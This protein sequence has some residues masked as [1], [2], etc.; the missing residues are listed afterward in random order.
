MS[1][2]I[3]LSDEQSLD[4]FPSNNP[5]DFT[6]QLTQT[7]HLGSCARVGL[8]DIS[9]PIPSEGRPDYVAVTSDLCDISYD[10]MQKVALLRKISLDENILRGKKSTQ[11]TIYFPKILYLPVRQKF[12]NAIHISIN[13]GDTPVQP[14]FSNRHSYCTL[15]I[16]H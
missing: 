15:E 12:F 11:Y 3:H 2:L 9:F 1:V 16:K 13:I 7:I 8:I 14:P 10:G 6:V 4:R 5:Y